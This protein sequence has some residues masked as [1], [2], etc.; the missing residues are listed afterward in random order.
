MDVRTVLLGRFNSS[1]S[2][3]RLVQTI[4]AAILSSNP[5]R[6]VRRAAPWLAPIAIAISAF[7]FAAPWVSAQAPQSRSLNQVA[8]FSFHPSSSGT[9]TVT[10]PRIIQQHATIIVGVTFS[11]ADISGVTIGE[12]GGGAGDVESLNR[13][14]P[15]SIFHNGPGGPFYTNFYYGPNHGNQ[16]A[17]IGA[18]TVTLNFSG[19]ATYALI[20]VAEVSGLACLDCQ[21]LDQSAY[22]E[23]LSPTAS[24][25][26]G[27][28]TTTAFNEYLFSW[29]ATEASDSTCSSPG[30]GWTLESQTNDPS[31]AAVCLLDQFVAAPG[32]SY[33]ASVKASPAANY[34]MEIVT[35]AKQIP[36]LGQPAVTSVNPSFGAQGQSLPGVVIAG[37]GFDSKTVC[38]FGAGITVNSCTV[39]SATQM[40]AKITIG[41]TAAVG[42]H[43]VTVTSVPDSNAGTTLPNAFS[44]TPDAAIPDFTISAA[45]SVQTVLP[46]GAAKFTLTLK[47]SGGLNSAVNLSC[48]PLPSGAACAFNPSSITP[49]GTGVQST[50]TVTTPSTL[51]AGNF[52]VPIT[53]TSGTVS[54]TQDVQVAVAVGG[55]TGA[56]SPTS[57]TI[58]VGGSANF[59]VNVTSSGGFGG[60]VSLV[61]SG[62]PSG[63]GCTFNPGVVDL[64]ANGSANSTL[65]VQVAFKPSISSSER[66][67]AN[68][69]LFPS[70]NFPPMSLGKMGLAVALLA[71]LFSFG[72]V[73]RPRFIAA[74]ESFFGPSG[75]ARPSR[76]CVAGLAAFAL[77][78]VFAAGLISCGGTT[79]RGSSS[80]SAATSTTGG[81]TGG[82]GSSG[83]T[84]GGTSGGSGGTGSVTTQVTVQAQSAGVTANLGTISV[85]VP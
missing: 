49:S 59:A 5:R 56:V 39:N 33:A 52:S 61:C 55:I 82:S 2:H 28:A 63:V 29:G 19:G 26:S 74:E 79:S 21:E 1:Y 38:S 16:L 11:P 3:S 68:R 73:L 12:V 30:N 8:T 32:L 23:S 6:S 17:G 48:G 31:G 51:A 80:G 71:A 67:P 42:P 85:T 46:G 60:Q 78:L 13:G 47:A 34:G 4:A 41:S 9:I 24:W 58:A 62:A 72:L 65:T 54:H 77:V 14:L 25:S 57:A 35:F 50:L 40:V 70:R 10:L 45:P 76:S 69:P 7:T 20:A 15:T 43:N 83:G 75:I 36:T 27:S 84:S 66:Q 64:V 22:N 44:V 18:G 37:S 53:A 81:G